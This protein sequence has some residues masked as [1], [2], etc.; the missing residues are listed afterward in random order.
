MPAA[1]S[2]RIASSRRRAVEA[3]GSIVRAS[4]LSSVVTDRNTSARL[5]LAMSARM[6]MSRVT[7]WLLVTM[8]IGLLK[9]ESTFRI[10][11]VILSSRSTG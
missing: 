6:S 3:R 4:P 5:R 7:V 2:S 10:E 8:P 9:S 11:R 1:L